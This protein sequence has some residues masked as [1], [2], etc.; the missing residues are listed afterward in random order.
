MSC[1]RRCYKLSWTCLGPRNFR[2]VF[3]YYVGA[4][5]EIAFVRLEGFSLLC[6]LQHVSELL[7]MGTAM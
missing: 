1:F 6:L 7:N 4:V 3:I 2:T 5:E